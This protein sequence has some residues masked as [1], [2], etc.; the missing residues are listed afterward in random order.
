MAAVSSCEKDVVCVFP[1]LATLISLGIAAFVWY[2]Y[3]T[4]RRPH[5]LVWAIAFT[6]FFLAS[7]SEWLAGLSGWSPLLARMYYLFGATLNVGYLALGL[8]WLMR[9]GPM[10][11]VTTLIV[12]ALSLVATVGLALAP[13][14]LDAMPE[15]G[16]QAMERPPHVR[17][18]SLLF[19]IGG[20][21][22]LIGGTLYSAWTMRTKPALRYRALGL[23][24]LTLGVMI[25]AG[26]GA[27]SDP[28]ALAVT[29]AIGALLILTGIWT[30]DK[31]VPETKIKAQAG[32]S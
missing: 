27:F 8:V 15:T 22:F 14:D 5:Q 13:V 30:A 16:W 10:A 21:L 4:R 29:N 19:N 7:T 12:V 31:R 24:I 17:I 32:T 3:V 26:G 9:P 28:N 23:A 6:F 1:F 11:T 2:Q 18:V 20:S 25:I